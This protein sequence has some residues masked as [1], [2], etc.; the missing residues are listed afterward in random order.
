M[1]VFNLTSKHLHYLAF[2]RPISCSEIL[3]YRTSARPKEVSLAAF[4]SWVTITS[5]LLFSTN[6]LHCLLGLC[7]SFSLSHYLLNIQIPLS[8]LLFLVKHHNILLFE[9][10]TPSW[11]LS[12]STWLLLSLLQVQPSRDCHT[13][14]VSHHLS[15]SPALNSFL[16]FNSQRQTFQ[17]IVII[18]TPEENRDLM[19]GTAS[20]LSCW[21]TS[22]LPSLDICFGVSYVSWIC[23]LA[24]N[25][26]MLFFHVVSY[27][28]F[29]LKVLKPQT[30][31]MEYFFSG[32]VLPDE[33][34]P[35]TLPGIS[36]PSSSQSMRFGNE[37]DQSWHVLVFYSCQQTFEGTNSHSFPRELSAAQGVSSTEWPLLQK[38]YFLT[39]LFFLGCCHLS[40]LFPGSRPGSCAKPKFADRAD[41]LFFTLITQ[42][43][44]CAYRVLTL[45]MHQGKGYSF[46]H[47]YGDDFV[48]FTLLP[49]WFILR[50][51]IHVIILESKKRLCCFTSN[52][53]GCTWSE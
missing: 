25:W 32:P 22:G 33:P 39:Q 26:W 7:S 37:L 36:S 10:L 27:G 18:I 23:K 15:R 1:F 48:S 8:C 46:V 51:L 5:H 45:Q 41:P 35:A 34:M 29:S 52:H 6:V 31:W 20:K 38:A 19:F 42:P 3:L 12:M 24:P 40:V 4:T 16:S 13:Q 53:L 44:W 49:Y 30:G 50:S 11:S 17:A 14:Q 43:V 9:F 2:E 28:K 47:F 21:N